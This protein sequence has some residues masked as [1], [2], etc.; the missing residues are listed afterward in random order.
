MQ[1]LIC[2]LLVVCSCYSLT[3][4][5]YHI[6]Y[7]LRGE[8]NSVMLSYVLP[9]VQ[10]MASAVLVTVLFLLGFSY[11]LTRESIDSRERNVLLGFVFGYAILRWV[12]ELCKTPFP[13]CLSLRLSLLVVE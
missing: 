7:A 5:A 9:S 12:A 2:L 10:A 6:N 13:L 8:D 11:P 1:W 3:S 4:L